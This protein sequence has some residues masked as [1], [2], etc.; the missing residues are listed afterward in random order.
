[1]KKELIYKILKVVLIPT[2]LAFIKEIKGLEN[3]PKT[4]FVIAANHASFI[5]PPVIKVIFQRHFKKKVFYLAKMELYSN[6]LKKL[7]IESS[8][9]ILVERGKNDNNAV[10]SATD[11]VFEG[12]IVGLFPEGTRSPDGKLYRGKTGAVR[13]ALAA[14]CPILPI[15]IINNYEF[16]PKHRKFPKLRRILAVKIGKPINIG[17]YSKKRLTK[18]LLDKLTD[19][20]MREIASLTGQEYV[21]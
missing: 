15:G 11:K 3:V 6:P 13:I 10:E 14:K 7:I 5:D 1:M 17:E 9:T 18:K 8:G 21:N 16:W 12:E 20:V 4:P 2:V 19:K